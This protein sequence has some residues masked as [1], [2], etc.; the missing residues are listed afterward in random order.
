[1]YDN[2]LAFSVSK[3]VSGTD[4]DLIVLCV[5]LPP[6]GSPAYTMTDNI[7][8]ID[9][10]ESYVLDILQTDTDAYVLITADFNARTSSENAIHFQSEGD[11]SFCFIHETFR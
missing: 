11:G 8:C 9:M 6:I 4:K 7:N 5:Y 1:M 3:K 2:V 10:S